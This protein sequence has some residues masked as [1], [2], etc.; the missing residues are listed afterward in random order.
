MNNEMTFYKVKGLPAS[1]GK[2]KGRAMHA[3]DSFE[4]IPEEEPIIVVARTL[5]RELCLNL[6]KHVVAVVGERGGVGSH[7]ASILRERGIPC[8]VGPSGIY[9]GIKS[10]ALLSVDGGS[11]TVI[12]LKSTED[13]AVSSPPEEVTEALVIN[14]Q[15]GS[16]TENNVFKP[17]PAGSSIRLSEEECYRPE[18]SYQQLRFDMLREGWEDSPRYLFSLAQCK[19]ERSPSGQVHIHKGPR[20]EDV[21]N[22]LLNNIDWFFL[23]TRHRQILIK[24]MISRLPTYAKSVNSPDPSELLSTIKRL[25]SEYTTLLRFIYL[26]QFVSDDLIEEWINL[27]RQVSDS[28]ASQIQDYLRSSYVADALNRDRHPGKSTVWRFPSPE[29]TTWD[30]AVDQQAMIRAD[31][32][33]LHETLQKSLELKK[34]LLV[35]YSQYRLVVPTVYQMSEEHYFVSSSICSYLNRAIDTASSLLY[36]RMQSAEERTKVFS[37]KLNELYQNLS[38]VAE[39][40]RIK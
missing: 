22:I 18:R 11:G 14:R 29:P 38:Q 5:N 34:D 16:V 28:V 32:S 17:C 12:Q 39:E 36:P 31:T 20:L 37:L 27:A 21:R 30:G 26:T 4:S 7:G 24:D 19:L 2:A 3:T 35:Q 1:K 9:Q 13:E 33:L 6:P 15:P 40:R 10:G 23:A 8:V 25:H